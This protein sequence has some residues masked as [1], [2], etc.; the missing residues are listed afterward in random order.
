MLTHFLKIQS[1]SVLTNSSGPTKFVR[2]YRLPGFV[3]S[4]LICVLNG[5][6]G[7]EILFAITELVIIEFV[8]TEFSYNRVSQYIIE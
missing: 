8:I 1:N 4:G 7:L 5:F 3:I 2:Y 6:L